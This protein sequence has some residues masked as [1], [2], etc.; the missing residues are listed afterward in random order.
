MLVFRKSKNRT[1]LKQAIALALKYDS[2]VLIEQG[3]DAREIEVGI[4]GNTD[5]KNNFTGRD[6]QRCGFL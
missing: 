1:D 4:L 3:V 5:V 2:R 6:C